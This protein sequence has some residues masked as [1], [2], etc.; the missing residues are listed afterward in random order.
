MYFALRDHALC[1]EDSAEEALVTL[2]L[3]HVLGSL[4]IGFV[5]L[6]GAQQQRAERMRIAANLRRHDHAAVE[7]DRPLVMAQLGRDAQRARL[8]AQVEELEDVVNPELA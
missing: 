4:E 1:T 7:V 5:D 2:A 8:P 6:A 3:L